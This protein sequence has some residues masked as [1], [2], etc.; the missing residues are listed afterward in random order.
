MEEEDKEEEKRRNRAPMFKKKVP[1][2][3]FKIKI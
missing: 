1:V 2:T 3:E